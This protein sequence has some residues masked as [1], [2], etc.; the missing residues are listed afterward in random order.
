M[1]AVEQ[2]VANLFLGLTIPFENAV[3]KSF[4]PKSA[5]GLDEKCLYESEFCSENIEAVEEMVNGIEDNFVVS[6]LK[7]YCLKKNERT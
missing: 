3:V 7:H 6:L 5:E 4:S 2:K 1:Q